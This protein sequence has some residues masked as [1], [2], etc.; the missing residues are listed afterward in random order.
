M[1]ARRRLVALDH[2]RLANTSNLHFPFPFK[3]HF[4]DQL[5]RLTGTHGAGHSA[6]AIPIIFSPSIRRTSS[7]LRMSAAKT[8]QRVKRYDALAVQYA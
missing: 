4:C 7:V 1:S 5:T 6:L 8:W 2:G 3:L